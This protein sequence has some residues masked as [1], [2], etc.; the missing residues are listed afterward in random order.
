MTTGTV[1]VADD[2]AAIRTVVT[3]AL[4]RAG[5][6]VRA[7]SNAAS[8]WR[9]VSEG[10]GDV[11]L[12]DVVR[13]DGRRAL[14]WLEFGRPFVAIHMALARYFEHF[15]AAATATRARHVDT[16]ALRVE[17]KTECRVVIAAGADM[18]PD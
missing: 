2:D 3:Q 14:E 12:T 5:Y 7:S 1:L 4:T 6:A 11:V 17:G 15:A 16:D 13:A 8:L 10:E 9:W 18:S